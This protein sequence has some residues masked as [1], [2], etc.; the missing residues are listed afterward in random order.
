MAAELA[1][2]S[3]RAPFKLGLKQVHLPTFS[4]SLHRTPHLSPSYAQFSVPLWFSKLDLRDYLYNAYAVRCVSIRSYIKLQ[5]LTQGSPTGLNGESNSRPQYKRWHRPR[6]LKRMTVELESPFVWPEEL[7]REML[8]EK[9]DKGQMERA[10][11]G[12]EE[13]QRGMG[14]DGDTVVDDPRR[15][16]MREQAKELLEGRAKWKPV[17]D[18]AFGRMSGK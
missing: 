12:Q 11:R 15:R 16:R 9:F 18:Q 6:S 4:I 14:S 5:R 1:T 2:R 17:G 3:A 8:D 13:M 10:G 7:G